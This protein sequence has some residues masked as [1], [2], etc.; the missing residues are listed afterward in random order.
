VIESLVI[1][2]YE[3]DAEAR[4]AAEIMASTDPWITLGRKF[5]NT[6]RAVTFEL[7]ESYVAILNNEVVG[8]ILISMP[9]P[10]IKGYIAGLAVH[11]DH[12]GK[13][14]GA[15]LLTFAEQR[16]FRDSPNVFLTVGSFNADAQRFYQRQGYVRVG[17]LIDFLIQ[18]HDEV[19]MR[20]NIGPWSTFTAQ[21]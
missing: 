12:R 4:A 16:I 14:I 3:T 1:R 11:A 7:T 9:I 18:G 20:K 8:V 6:Y 2:R 17:D 21:K 10:L 19:L 13:G 5:E 15:K